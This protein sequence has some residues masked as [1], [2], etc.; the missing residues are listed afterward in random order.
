MKK[1]KCQ[2]THEIQRN[3]KPLTKTKETRLLQDT[4][5]NAIATE[6]EQVAQANI[7]L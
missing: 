5:T 6:L 3:S 1:P 4:R 7:N 2:E